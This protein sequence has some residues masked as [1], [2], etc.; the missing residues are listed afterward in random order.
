LTYKYDESYLSY[1][2]INKEKIGISIDAD[3]LS[4]IDEVC[5]AR[6]EARSAWFERIAKRVIEDEEQFIG[7]MESPL[8]RGVARALAAHPSILTIFANLS[9]ETL[10]P[11][12]R[13]RMVRELEKQSKRGAE[14]SAKRKK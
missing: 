8:Y 4:R 11:E 1:M 13:Q 5:E 7:D 14:R 2:S 9:M 10:T 6:N 3:L 12:E